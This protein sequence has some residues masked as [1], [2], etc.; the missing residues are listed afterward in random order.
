MSVQPHI[1]CDVGRET[2][3]WCTSYDYPPGGHDTATAV[4]KELARLG[5]H[6]TKDGRDICP[7]CWEKGKR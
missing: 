4:R 5:W 3:D 2:G 1:Q 6:R 7:P